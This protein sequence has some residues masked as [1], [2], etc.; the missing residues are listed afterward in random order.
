[1][2][3]TDSAF[4]CHWCNKG[5]QRRE[6]L[7]KH[8]LLCEVIYKKGNTANIALPSQAQLF[9][10]VTELT[11]RCQL[12]EA[13]V[14]HLENGGA[15][16]RK[17][18]DVLLELNS[19]LREKPSISF[20]HFVDTEIKVTN[21]H[22]MVLIDGFPFANCIEKIMRSLTFHDLTP[23]QIIGNKVYIFQT[24]V[25]EEWTKPISLVFF[26]KLKIKILKELMAWKERNGGDEVDRDETLASKYN[27]ALLK[28]MK[29]NFTVDGHMA[30]R[31]R[32][33][34]ANLNF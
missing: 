3:S 21:D 25:F 15:K 2:A 28:V 18:R 7:N 19:E 31:L 29:T 11:K 1:M 26:E 34:V 24:T 33:L 17:T 8:E 12:L 22:V 9:T 13:R 23:M 30:Q 32:S 14:D 27:S 5:Y 16:K 4:R 6:N 20:D 10:M